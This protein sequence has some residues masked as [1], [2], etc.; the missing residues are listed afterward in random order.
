MMDDSSHPTPHDALFKRVFGELEHSAALVRSVLPD[1]LAARVDWTRI[2]LRSGGYVD[3]DL[4]G[5]AS[6]LVFS[7]WVGEAPALFYLLVEHQSSADPTM[8]WRMW[9]YVTRLWERH[10]ETVDARLE[11]PLVIPIVVYHGERAWSVADSIGPM[12]RVD[13]GTRAIAAELMPRFTYLLDDLTRLDAEGLRA[14]GL[15]ALATLTL[16]ALRTASDRSFASTV[17]IFADL[18]E[19]VR[20]ARDGAEALRTLFSYLSIVSRRDEGLVGR[21]L[22]ELSEPLREDVMDLVEMLAALEREEGRTEG[23]VEG[24]AE[25]L[26]K[27][28]S[29]RFGAVP[30]T[31][32][33][34]VREASLDEL[35]RW[36]ER[37]LTATSLDE[38]WD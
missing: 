11:L 35:D 13:D 29:L 38:L 12:I 23:R 17:G 21:V 16:W 3:A 26:L 2:E 32:E 24:R 27:Q 7:A 5:L 14:R 34:R 8:P 9:R 10:A 4:Q 20:A 33:R 1:E 15:P 19:E 6:D 28:L 25:I 36:A 18:F 30:E 31:A 22:A 37:V